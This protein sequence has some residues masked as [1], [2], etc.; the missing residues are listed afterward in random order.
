MRTRPTFSI[1]ADLIIK[2]AELYDMDPWEL[3]RLNNG[4]MGFRPRWAVAWV[5]AQLGR[6]Y[7]RQSN[8]YSYVRIARLLG[9]ADHTTVIYSLKQAEKLREQE[10]KFRALTDELLA[11]TQTQGPQI[12][13][14]AA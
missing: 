12:Q 1:A 14:K 2:A 4:R 6:G 9:F 13:I 11:T 5:L 8:P 7:T 3:P 10:P